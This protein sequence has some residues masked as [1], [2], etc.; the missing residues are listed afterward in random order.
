MSR[1][2]ALARVF[3]G[4]LRH[5]RSESQK[6]LIGLDGFIG[7]EPCGLPGDP[8]RFAGSNTGSPPKSGLLHPVKPSLGEHPPVSEECHQEQPSADHEIGITGRL[9]LPALERDCQL[10]DLSAEAMEVVAPGAVVCVGEQVAVITQDLPDLH[11]IVCSIQDEA[12][13]VRFIRPLS[14]EVIALGSRL[15]RRVRS[16]RA[17]RAEIDLPIRVHFG[18]VGYDVLVSNISAGGLMMM[19]QGPVRRGERKLFR[20]GQALMI[21]FP[22]LLPIGGNIRWTCGAKCGVMFSKLLTLPTAEE[23]QRLGHLS[24]TWLDVVRSAHDT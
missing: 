15:K 4:S 11:G 8:P 3:A 12:F 19:T 22:E 10:F 23:I 21:E 6:E 7:N 18:G 5:Y 17:L 20:Q 24:Q 1:F 16:P 2:S 14:A 9:R 13:G